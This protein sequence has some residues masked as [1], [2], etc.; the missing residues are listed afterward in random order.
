MNELLRLF[1]DDEPTLEVHPLA[2]IF[3]MMADDE[4]ADLAADIR[5]HGLLHPIVRTVDGRVLIDGRNRLKACEI[6]GV[7]PHFA[8]MVRDEDE[9]RGLIESANLQRR[10]MT[11]AQRAVAYAL[12]HPETEQGKRNDLSTKQTSSPKVNRQTLS[13][14]REIIPYDDLVQRVLAGCSLLL[15]NSSSTI[16]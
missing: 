16:L 12:M 15:M 2:K 9:A 7:R 6:A 4:L 14:A 13:E 11:G 8:D 1:A 10:H 3:P 5:A